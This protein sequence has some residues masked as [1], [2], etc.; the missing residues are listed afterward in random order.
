MLEA[1]VCIQF[2]RHNSV[3]RYHRFAR[4]IHAL[5]KALNEFP[6]LGVD[7]ISYQEN[8]DT[9]TPQGEMVF[10]IMASLAQLFTSFYDSSIDRY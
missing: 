10:T 3:W 6:P 8:I 1:F 9:T 4:S 5:I 2:S 7:F